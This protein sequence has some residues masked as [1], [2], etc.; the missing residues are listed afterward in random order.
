MPRKY[1]QGQYEPKNPEKYKGDPSK[2]RYLSS[3][4][5]HFFEWCDRSPSV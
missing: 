5:K 4:E 1:H 2:I 3:Y